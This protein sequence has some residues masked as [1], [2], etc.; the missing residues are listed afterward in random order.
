MKDENCHADDIEQTPEYVKY[1][2][3]GNA[4]NIRFFISRKYRFKQSLYEMV[5]QNKLLLSLHFLDPKR[6]RIRNILQWT[7]PKILSIGNDKGKPGL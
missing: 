4:R 2:I 6:G 3:I 7:Q 1:I 5:F